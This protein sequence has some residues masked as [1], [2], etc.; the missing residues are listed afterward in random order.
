MVVVVVVRVVV[1]HQMA[2]AIRS[3]MQLIRMTEFVLIR[4]SGHSN[5]I[6]TWR[7]QTLVLAV[8]DEAVVAVVAKFVVVLGRVEEVAEDVVNLLRLHLQHRRRRIR[9]PVLVKLLQLIQML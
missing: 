4:I 6:I 5:H 7:L 2:R 9:I 1:S 3:L 8:E